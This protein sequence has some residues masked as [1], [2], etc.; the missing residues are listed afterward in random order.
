V[1]VE[2]GSYQVRLI[3]AATQAAKKQG[4]AKKP[5]DAAQS[6]KARRAYFV[7]GEQKH[8]RDVAAD[9]T[10]VSFNALTL[11]PQ[12]SRI[13]AWIEADGGALQEVRYVEL[14]RK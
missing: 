9:Q 13:Q 5:S 7:C 3:F 14:L 11:S 10:E 2:A 4:T 6:G 12:A 1:Q 8:A